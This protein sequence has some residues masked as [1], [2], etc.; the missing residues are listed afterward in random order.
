MMTLLTFVCFLIGQSFLFTGKSC[1][2]S[3][4]VIWY[5]CLVII[6]I[7]Y[8]SLVRFFFQKKN[9][10]TKQIAL[11]TFPFANIMI[12]QAVPFLIVLG[13]CICLPCVLIVFRYFAE[14]EGANTEIIDNLP[15]RVFEPVAEDKTKFLSMP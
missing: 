9:N 4:P 3:S 13:I 2:N 11:F 6:I 1:Q 14:P 10:K 5:Y 12:R 8:I 7:I 15:T